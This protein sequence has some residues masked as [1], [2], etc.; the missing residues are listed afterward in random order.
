MQNL[1]R[2]EF[3]KSSA[4]SVMGAGLAWSVFGR[5][6]SAAPAAAYDVVIVGAGIAGLS[7]G[8][9]LR[10]KR[11]LILEK[12]A[13]P[14]G[15]ARA[16]R[17]EGMPYAI[18]VSYLGKP[19]G[20]LRE[21]IE[22]LGLNLREIPAPWHA[23]YRDGEIF[24]GEDGLARLLSERSSAA[25]FDR[26]RGEVLAAA[27]DYADIPE[28]DMTDKLARL[29]DITAARWLEMEKYPVIFRPICNAASRELFGADLDEISA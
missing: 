3:L 13:R 19:Y 8:F 25:D 17:F 27:H 18:G 5:A 9:S 29:D 21:I 14:G 24:Y 23:Y 6:A 7:A 4:R 15:R 2:R 12:E 28:L 1:P 11:I 10:G 26:F 20:A 22:F 16:G